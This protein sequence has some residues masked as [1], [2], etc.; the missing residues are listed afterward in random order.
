MKLRGSLSEGP[1][2]QNLFS[3]STEP[4]VLKEAEQR[5]KDILDADYSPVDI[6]EL[7]QSYKHL[8]LRQRTLLS[9]SLFK[10]KTLFKG[11]LGT[12][13]VRPIGLELIDNVQPYHARAYPVP[14]AHETKTHKELDRLVSIGVMKKDYNSPWAAPTFIQP[15]KTGDIR[16][17]TDF[18]RLNAALKR[19]PF[20]LPISCLS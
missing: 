11:G 18:R 8:D 13:N 17:L 7:V 14:K 4:N 10:Y 2:I 9:N 12:C 5:Q 19:K 16:V 15:K 6:V 1:H 3:L 20:P